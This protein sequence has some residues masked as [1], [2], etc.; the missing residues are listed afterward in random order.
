MIFAPDATETSSGPVLATAITLLVLTNL[1]VGARIV[2]RY[3]LTPGGVRLEDWIMLVAQV[4][5]AIYS[6]IVV[7]HLKLFIQTG[8]IV[9][10]TFLLLGVQAGLGH[11]K[12]SLTIDNAVRASM[13][14]SMT[15]SCLSSSAMIC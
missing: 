5:E 15:L 7:L 12:L 13:V 1:I 6:Q 8:F 2:I 10:S 9:M 11:H 4:W 3:T 14:I